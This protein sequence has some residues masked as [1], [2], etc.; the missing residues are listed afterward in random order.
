MPILLPDTFSEACAL[1][2]DDPDRI[3]L[4]GGTDL[5]AAWP[6]RFDRH[7]ATYIDLSKLT[8]LK[9]IDWMDDALVLGAATTY[10]DVLRDARVPDDFPLLASA[11]LRVGALQIQTR[12]TW[13]GNIA[14]ASP[15][16]DG[17]AVL[18]AHDAV[19]E[20]VSANAE[21]HVPLCEFYLGH[22]RTRRLPG[23][24]IRAVRIPRRDYSVQAFEK[25]GARAGQTVSRLSLTLARSS[26]GWRVV[27]GGMA[28]SV[29][30]CPSLERLIESETRLDSPEALLPAIRSDLSP[31][32]DL[33][34]S[35]VYREQVFARVA[36]MELLGVCPWVQGGNL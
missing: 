16:A 30:R 6:E 5:L 21:E 24:L 34:A 32:D 22:G 4:A 28:P 14:N 7:E 25:V 27:A 9:T 2:A 26:A 29:A 35:A 36:F 18:M 15:F 10:W 12:G 19:L 11:A 33:H 8:E 31:V 23:Q 1:L 17:A 13:A 3:A 20:L